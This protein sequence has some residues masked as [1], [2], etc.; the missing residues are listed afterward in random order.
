V[1]LAGV[2]LAV[3]ES[4][5]AKKRFFELPDLIGAAGFSAMLGIALTVL[6]A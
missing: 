1:A 3:L 2:A 5:L 4:A 6:F